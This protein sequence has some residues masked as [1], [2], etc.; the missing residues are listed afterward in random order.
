MREKLQKLHQSFTTIGL[1]DAAKQIQVISH[2]YVNSSD[3]FTTEINILNTLADILEELQGLKF[4]DI[5]SGSQALPGYTINTHNQRTVK[6]T[7]PLQGHNKKE[8]LTGINHY[9]A[10]FIKHF[11]EVRAERIS[12]GNTGKYNQAINIV[13]SILQEFQAAHKTVTKGSVSKL[14]YKVLR[15]TQD[16]DLFLRIVKRET[17][18]M[19]D[20][21]RWSGPLERYRST[22]SRYHDIEGSSWSEVIENLDF[23]LETEMQKIE[24]DYIATHDISP[25]DF[26][27]MIRSFRSNVM[28]IK[29]ASFSIIK[30]AQDDETID[31]TDTEGKDK[32]NDKKDKKES[33]PSSEEA[34]SKPKSDFF[35]KPSILSLDPQ[36]I[37]D[38]TPLRS[39][40]TQI[41]TSGSLFSKAKSGSKLTPLAPWIV[42]RAYVEHLLTQFQE[43]YASLINTAHQIHSSLYEVQA[44]EL[45]MIKALRSAAAELKE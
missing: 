23:D 17:P 41:V 18:K 19:K 39:I 3:N 1:E 25:S 21:P 5:Y 35:K 32:T 28:E 6:S 14:L 45:K 30:R 40:A 27:Y 26:Y 11:M 44:V 37:S 16:I 34:K 29:K 15:S 20:D 13:T 2:L 33:V 22:M 9:L 43:Q 42:Y 24:Q 12:Y 36:A 7:E 31:L 10:S 8:I 38:P 4:Q